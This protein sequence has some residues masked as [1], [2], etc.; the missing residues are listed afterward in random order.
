MNTRPVFDM[1]TIFYSWFI[2]HFYFS[3]FFLSLGNDFFGQPLFSI[4]R[5][6]MFNQWKELKLIRF[7][8][9]FFILCFFRAFKLK[10]QNTFYEGKKHF[11]C[12]FFSICVLH[13][14]CSTMIQLLLGVSPSLRSSSSWVLRKRGTS[15]VCG[16]KQLVY[17][18]YDDRLPVSL[19]SSQSS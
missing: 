19:K 10:K 6:I 1:H 16:Q 2:I 13:S 4:P 5:I 15:S 11:A 7:F 9:I 14:I 8:F 12:L 18:K 3:L 17:Y